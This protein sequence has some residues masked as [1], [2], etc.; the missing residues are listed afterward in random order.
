MVATV[1]RWPDGSLRLGEGRRK[2]ILNGYHV[3]RNENP[4]ASLAGLYLF[5]K[6][7]LALA[8][9]SAKAIWQTSL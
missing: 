7:A 5:L 4:K 9:L 6:M 8:F 1:W 2:K 3:G